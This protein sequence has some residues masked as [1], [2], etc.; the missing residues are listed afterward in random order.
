M[1]QTPAFRKFCAI[2]VETSG[3]YPRR[4]DRVIEYG[5]VKFQNSDVI[6]EI[7]TLIDVPCKIH[8]KALSVH[9]IG[10][11]DLANGLS[12]G[13][14]WNEL[15]DF[16]GELPLVAHNARFDL[17]FIRMELGR[18]NQE[19]L[20]PVFCTLVQA[21]K[22]YFFLPNHRLETVARHLLGEIPN[23]CRL[24]RALSDARLAGKIWIEMAR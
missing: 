3:L 1:V 9:G 11:A 21:R 14:A 5:A 15:L 7:S 24:H 19:I 6:D 12:P 18:I 17:S 13:R 16:I 2:D 22:K 4:G 23:D 10:K 8:P 20:N